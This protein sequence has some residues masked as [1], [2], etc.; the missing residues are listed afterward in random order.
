MPKFSSTPKG[1]GNMETQ[2][3]TNSSTLV[4]DGDAAIVMR[5]LHNHTILPYERLKSLVQQQLES[6]DSFEPVIAQIEKNK[7]VENT[8]QGA[9]LTKTG[10]DWLE[11]Q[12]GELDVEGEDIGSSELKKPYDV[13]KLKMEPKHLSVFQA[14][15]KIEKN[16]IYLNPEFQRAFVWDKTRQSRLIES[17][18]I[19]IPLP[20]FYLDATDQIK[21]N[22]VDGLQR[23]TTLFNYCRKQTFAL[24][25][26]QFL[27]EL[28][29]LKFDKLPPQYKVL[30]EDDTQL[31]FYNLMPGTPIEAKY[32]I[33]SRV[34]T[35]G[36][37]LTPQEI[38]H[39]L[40]QGN[41]TILLNR[42]AKSDAF[43]LATDGVVESLRM[44]DRELILRALAFMLLGVDSYKDFKDQDTFLLH[45]MAELNKLT[46][47]RLAHLEAEF[48]SS[49][50]KVRTIFGRYSFRKFYS[51]GGRRSPLNK[52]LFEVWVVTVRDYEKIT[53][54]AKKEL[55]IDEFIEQL[56]EYDSPLGRAI[57]S[58][59]GSN[60]AVQSRFSEISTILRKVMA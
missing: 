46:S 33:F 35:G 15:R 18:L 7:W 31:L 3:D 37:Q 8:N 51:R 22:V 13:A 54:Q 5:V 21:W 11:K 29:G 4:V 44:S 41:V 23:L 6:E 14:L 58:S 40:N 16:E 27:N 38:R 39:A 9:R 28:E 60:T 10:L 20:A 30:I 36:M 47:D 55:I 26:M 48:F 52:A 12:G 50:D 43:R 34:N 19:R 1:I 53:L 2:P 49:L 57:S 56:N 42:M 32:T 24:T 17:I 25:G 59:T 45:A